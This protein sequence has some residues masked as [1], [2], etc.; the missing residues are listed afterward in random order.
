MKLNWQATVKDMVSFLYF[1]GF[2]IKDNRSPGTSG[3]TF[4]APT[5]TFHQDNAYSDSPFHGFYKLADDR[6]ITPNMFLSAKYAYFNTGFI[7]T[8]EGGM[9]P[10][11]PA[12]TSLRPRSHTGSTVQSSNVR[13][14]MSVNLDLNSFLNGFGA[15]HDVKYG[16]GWRRVNATTSTLWPGNGI[17][18][19]ANSP[20]AT[21]AELFRE[22]SGTNRTNYAD[23]YVGDTM[24]WSR[25]TL[26]VGVRYDRQG[27]AALPGTHGGQSRLPECGARHRLR[28]LRR[29]VPVEQ[30]LATCGR[31]LFAGRSAQDAGARQLRAFCRPARFGERRLHEPDFVGERRRVLVART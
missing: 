6:V 10:C 17:L 31:Y 12:A 30:R 25:T 7:L 14:Q 21:F 9:R 24:S 18:A 2:K 27:G 19:L 15:T 28:R 23:L 11:R 16:L 20:T 1:D 5:A 13:P 26:D 8:P 4:D 3:I 29:A 22:G